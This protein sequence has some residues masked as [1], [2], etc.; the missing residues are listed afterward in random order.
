[1]NIYSPYLWESYKKTEFDFFHYLRIYHN[2]YIILV[3]HLIYRNLIFT[4]MCNGRHDYLIGGVI[5]ITTI[6]YNIAFLQG[7][8][9]YI[10]KPLSKNDLIKSSTQDLQTPVCINYKCTNP[11]F[12]EDKPVYHKSKYYNIITCSAKSL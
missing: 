7:C 4:E 10:I 3:R 6:V 5:C 12:L 1:M 9:P 2:R 8:Q 11:Y